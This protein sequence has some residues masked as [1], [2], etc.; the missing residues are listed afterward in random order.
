VDAAAALIRFMA[1]LTP[2]QRRTLGKI[3][4]DRKDIAGSAVRSNVGN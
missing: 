1:V 2:E 3:V 4:L